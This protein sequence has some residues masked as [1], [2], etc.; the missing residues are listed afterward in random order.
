MRPEDA[1]TKLMSS[2]HPPG[3][4]RVI[5]PLSNSYDFAKVCIII[6]FMLMSHKL[7][8]CA[9][10]WLI[11]KFPSKNKK[12]KDSIKGDTVFFYHKTLKGDKK[13]FVPIKNTP[14]SNHL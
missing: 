7:L 8:T 13:L 3:P 10:D 9:I 4:I 1:Q 6:Y 2:V 12:R 14:L 5:G 11:T